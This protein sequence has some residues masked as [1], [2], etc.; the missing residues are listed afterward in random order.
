M[1]M[2]YNSVLCTSI[3][4]SICLLTACSTGTNKLDPFEKTNRQVH[5]FNKTFDKLYAKPITKLYKKTM[6][7]PIRQAVTRSFNN[8]G[9]IPTM[10]N[11]ILQKQPKLAV[12]DASRFVINT[13]L[14]IFGLFDV[15]TPLGLT[16]HEED[17]G[18]TFARWGNTQSAYIVLP[19]LGP[20]TV[21]DTVGRAGNMAFS[22]SSYFPNKERNAY[23][24]TYYL[25]KRTNADEAIDALEI[26]GV[27]EYILMRNAYLQNRN[28]VIFGNT[29]KATLDEPPE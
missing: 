23:L 11:H 2:V 29:P 14:G 25:D 7:Q 17:L 26:A 9:E 19:F 10:I 13:T 28:F 4:A 27:D 16:R 24:V 21:R 3:T 20:S 22:P 12:N 6:P 5:K 8:V 15:A 1:Y 18:K